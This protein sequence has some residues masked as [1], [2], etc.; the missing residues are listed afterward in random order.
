LGYR[1]LGL[2]SIGVYLDIGV[3]VGHLLAAPA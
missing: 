2:A 3:V 1:P